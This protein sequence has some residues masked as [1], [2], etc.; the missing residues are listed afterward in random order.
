MIIHY[1]IRCLKQ[2]GRNVER[3]SIIFLIPVLF[4]VGIAFLYGEDQ[5]SFVIIGDTGDNYNIG[6]LN[7]DQVP[8]LNSTLRSQFH[9]YIV[10]SGLG[11]KT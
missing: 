9:Y 10:E 1:T 11:R 7:E 3:M 8:N 2:T 4:I 5:S 6:V